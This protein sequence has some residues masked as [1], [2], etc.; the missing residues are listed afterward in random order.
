MVESVNMWSAG[1]AV[2]ASPRRTLIG[3]IIFVGVVFAIAALGYVLAGWSFS[4]AVYMVTLTVFSVGYGEVRPID[5]SVLRVLTLSTMVL[6]CT[7]M[8]FL[9][10]AL[11]QYFSAVQLRR[12][13]G[14][15]RMKADIERLSG[16]V[17]I[18]G[19]GRIGVQLAKELHQ[20][21]RRFVV[22]DRNE[23]KV[24]E[25]QAMGYLALR[26]DATEE[27][28]LASA[29]I[30][31]ASLL[32]T[33][34]PDDAAN[35]F[36]TLTARS[37]N[38][39]IEIIARGEAPTT[40]SKLVSAGADHVVMPTHI[41]AER[42]AEMILF[43]ATATM[44]D[45]SDS[46]RDMKRRLAEIGLALE[47]VTAS[48]KAELT[49]GTVGEAE[50]RSSGAFFVVQIDRKSGQSI[51]HPAEDVRIEEGD[52]ILLVVRSSRV[53]AGALFSMDMP[54]MRQGRSYVG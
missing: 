23:N 36:I 6:G 44:L 9:T 26:A 39:K 20:A 12:I 48:P 35:V 27:F 1:D 51:A 14:I 43:P 38:P 13:L 34:L 17:I 22:L 11:V 28:G 42:I 15:D 24:A 18:C 19:F 52:R 41:G 32:A 3:A 54:K 2:F 5:T 50:R 21:R 53:S 40:E 10:G 46:M 4:D 47:M 16:H 31:R 45:G 30:D 29:R 7:G 8:I 49:G 25:A 37:V 33:V